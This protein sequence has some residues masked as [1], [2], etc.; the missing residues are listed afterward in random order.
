M[1]LDGLS[2]SQE[3]LP[4]VGLV[5]VAHCLDRVSSSEAEFRAILVDLESLVET[6]GAFEVLQAGYSNVQP[7]VWH[8]KF[9]P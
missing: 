2:D 5:P 6:E 3:V 9:T 4:G 7:C 8:N 1:G